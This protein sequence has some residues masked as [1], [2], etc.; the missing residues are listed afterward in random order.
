ML[1]VEVPAYRDTSV[2][3]SV[4]VNFCVINGKR[5]RSQPQHFTFT[6]LAG[7]N[8]QSPLPDLFINTFDEASSDL[9]LIVVSNINS[10]VL[11]GSAIPNGW[12]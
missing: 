12:T 2:C 6:P 5:K 4:K 11:H 1:F 10:K 9:T 3:Q 7:R 8:P